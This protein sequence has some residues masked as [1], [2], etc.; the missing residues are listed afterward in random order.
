MLIAIE[1]VETALVSYRQSQARVTALKDAEK[2]SN[3][4]YEL[5]NELYK[6]GLGDF[7]N[8]LE[9]QRTKLSAQEQVVVAQRQVSLN[10]V[11]L[12]KALGG[13]WEEPG[14]DANVTPVKK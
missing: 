7:L 4:A 1:D 2:A 12:Y 9:A 3:R 8:V 14:P 11:K 13:G 6:N 5:A 10:L